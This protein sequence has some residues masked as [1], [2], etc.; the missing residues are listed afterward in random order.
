MEEAEISL[1]ADWKGT[2]KRALLTF[3]NWVTNH[4][5]IKNSPWK[6]VDRSGM[7]PFLYLP[8]TCDC[9]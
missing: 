9:C 2:S 7:L 3:T 5:R 4:N 8:F 6:T 1:K